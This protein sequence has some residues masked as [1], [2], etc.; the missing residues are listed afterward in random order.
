LFG[1]SQKQHMGTASPQWN[2][3]DRCGFK[4]SMV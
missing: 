1:K 4:E 3:T 2:P